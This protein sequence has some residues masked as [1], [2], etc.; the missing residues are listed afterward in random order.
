MIACPLCN[1]QVL[2]WRNDGLPGGPLPLDSKASF[3]CPTKERLFKGHSSTHYKRQYWGYNNQAQY[4]LMSPPYQIVWTDKNKKLIIY[5]NSNND[6]DSLSI[7][8]FHQQ[9]NAEWKDVLYWTFRLK[10]LK[11]FL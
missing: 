5:D 7:V 4:V 11:A 6:R 2:E 3:C 8:Y 9:E 1:K 10:N